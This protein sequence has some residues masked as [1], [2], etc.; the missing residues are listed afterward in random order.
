MRAAPGVQRVGEVLISLVAVADD[1]AGVAGQDAAGVDRFAGPV[2]GMR[3]GEELGA[4]DV[5]V[6]QVPGGPGGGLVGVQHRGAKQSP[7]P[8]RE[9]RQ[10][11]GGL[12]HAGHEPGRDVHAGQRGDQPGGAGDRQVVRADRQRRLAC[13]PGPYCTRPVTPPAPARPRSPRTPGSI[14]PRPGLVTAGGG[15]GDASNTCRFCTVPGTGSPVRS[16]RSSRTRPAAQHR[17]T[18][19]G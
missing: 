7:E 11:P 15:G 18:G 8:V 13:T 16:C 4:R 17:V 6:A 1:G 9:R 10:Q 19:M 12:P 2:A 14:S 3:R 5:H